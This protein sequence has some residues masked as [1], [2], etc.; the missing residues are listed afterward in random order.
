MKYLFQLCFLCNSSLGLIGQGQGF[1]GPR[2]PL[3]CWCDIPRRLVSS[4]LCPVVATLTITT[5][6]IFQP[7]GMRWERPYHFLFKSYNRK[8]NISLLLTSHWPELSHKAISS[9]KRVWGRLS[10]SGWIQVQP[11]TQ[12]FC[13]KTEQRERRI[14]LSPLYIPH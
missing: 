2:L 10:D 8:M 5:V 4:S 6:C 9:C 7:A 1:G 3:S 14:C 12:R 13:N 11:K